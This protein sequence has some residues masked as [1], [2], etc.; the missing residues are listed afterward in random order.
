MFFA[1]I[2]QVFVFICLFIAAYAHAQTGVYPAKTIRMVCPA[3]PGGI[4]DILGRIIAQKLGDAFGQTV[5]VD[6]RP[7]AGTVLGTNLVAKAPA[8]GYTLLFT[9][10][11][12]AS[13]AALYTKLPFDTVK[14]FAPVAPVGQS[15]YVLA[16]QPSLGVASVQELVALAK[17]KP[18]QLQ[19]PTAGQGTITHMAGALFM[20]NTGIRMQDVPFK[21]GSPA[22]VAFLSNQMPVIIN[23]IAEILPHLRAGAKVRALAV[24]TA[25]RAAELPEVPTLAE[26]GV[27]NSEVV[28]KTGVYAPAGVPRA[29]VTR[30]NAE[31]N[32]ALAQP[33]VQE[34]FARQGLATVGGTPGELGEY[35]QSEI[36]RWSK[37]VK[38]MGIKV[39]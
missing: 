7:G 10:A 34:R 24:T 12:L 26:A 13:N 9:S 15:F 33:D 21:G 8:D 30:L 18:N 36:A 35:I 11:S 16:V 27:P 25:K 28:S 1:K 32:R 2:L 19:I 23:P 6:N 29:V 5:I 37:V 17:A 14:D 22:L 3:V 4:S 39:E 20:M 38:A 31:I